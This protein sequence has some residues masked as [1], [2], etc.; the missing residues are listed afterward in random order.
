MHPNAEIDFRY[1]Q[2]K[3]L[4]KVL[5]ELQPKDAAASGEGS[6]TVASKVSDFATRVADDVS[7]ES[8]RINVEDITSKLT[9][10]T[11]GPYQ[12]VFIQ[13]IE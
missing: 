5:I 11:R 7:L 2:C 13:E 3:N 1:T 12:N 8:N 4:F 9:D 10:E 6:D